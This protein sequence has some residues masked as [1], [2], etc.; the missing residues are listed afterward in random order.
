MTAFLHDS[1]RL[2]DT[3]L[4][5]TDTASV[6]TTGT[7]RSLTLTAS[8]LVIFDADDT[9]WESALFFQRAEER[10]LQL[11]ESLGHPSSAVAP[12]VRRRDMD[13]LALTGYGAGPYLNT[14]HQV[15]RELNGPLSSSALDSMSNIA[16][17]LLNHPVILFSGARALLQML[18]E[19][20]CELVL[21]TMGEPDH[22]L[23]KYERSGLSGFFSDCVVVPLKT[24]DVLSG[25]AS[26]R[27]ILPSR[28]V[29]VGNSPRS[30]VN[31]ALLAGLHVIHVHRSRTWEAENETIHTPELVNTVK[32]LSEVPRILA[33][34]SLL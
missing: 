15:L 12:L 11:A 30:D 28:S 25:I 21:C 24:P 34:L 27:G 10:F 9:L 3:E 2:D 8:T 23:S 22:Q 14:L 17:Q 31:P 4:Y 26:S 18:T 33:D 6:A 1:S 13:R 16:D 32:D 29:M 20:G 7:D 5:S 19:S